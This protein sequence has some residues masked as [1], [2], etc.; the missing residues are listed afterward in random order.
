[1]AIDPRNY[2]L[3][4]LR[5]ASGASPR[6]ASPRSEARWPGDDAAPEADDA[7][8]G[9]RSTDRPPADAAFEASVARDLV[10]MEGR[11]GPRE[12]PY[13]PALPASLT[14]EALIFEWLEFLVLQAGRE[15]VADALDFYASVGWLGGD[16]AEALHAYLPGIDDARANAANDLDADDHRVS[17][18]YV[19]RLATLAGR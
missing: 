5:A 9:E 15:S 1:M 10:T 14:A 16:A 12:R 13:L 6:S 3:D 8:E 7:A 19:A 18:H 4:E 17:L 11:E 2:D